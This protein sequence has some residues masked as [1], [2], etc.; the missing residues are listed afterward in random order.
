M[1]LAGSHEAAS[2]KVGKARNYGD[3]YDVIA[4][5]VAIS[6]ACAKA[7]VP[8]WSPGQLRQNAATRLRREFGLAGMHNTRRASGARF[9]VDSMPPRVWQRDPVPRTG[10]IKSWVVLEFPARSRKLDES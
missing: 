2:D 4:Y 3:R 7:G 10:S 5:R 1:V 6:R 9:A 8:S